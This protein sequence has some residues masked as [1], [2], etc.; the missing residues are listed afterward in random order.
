MKT[1]TLSSEICSYPLRF[2]LWKDFLQFGLDGT[3]LNISEGTLLKK[4]NHMTIIIQKPHSVCI[5]AQRSIDLDLVTSL[6]VVLNE[7]VNVSI[8][9]QTVQYS[10]LYVLILHIYVV[11]G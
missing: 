7:S 9:L 2:Y 5:Q 3:G 10:S 4:K 8:L 6:N 1:G 11:K